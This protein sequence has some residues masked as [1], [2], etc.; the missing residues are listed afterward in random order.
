MLLIWLYGHGSETEKRNITKDC[1]AK[2]RNLYK[3]TSY[4]YLD[5][6]PI[7][8]LTL[9][10]LKKTL[11]RP[12]I[13]LKVNNTEDHEIRD[14]SNNRINLIGKVDVKLASNGWKT[15]AEIRVNGGTRPTIV[16]R[17]LMGK[18]GL[19]LMQANPRGEAMSIQGNE[20]ASGNEQAGE[21]EEQDMDPW[22]QYFN[23]LFPKTVH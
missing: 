20:S 18:L 5:W 15:R 17:E 23:K 21:P 16:G 3:W 1:R 6:L 4:E 22:Q 19:Q 13:D 10:D 12:G 8:I 14:Y 2:A 9:D 7:S 11:G